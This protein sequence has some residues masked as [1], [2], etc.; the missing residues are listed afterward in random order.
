MYPIGLLFGIGFDTATEVT[1]LV[2]AGS[3]A[4]RPGCP[5]TR[6]C[7]CRCCSPPG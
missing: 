2:M 3:A 6:S 7:A 1:L 5:G 4:P